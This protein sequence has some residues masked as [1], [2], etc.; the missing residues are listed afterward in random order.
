MNRCNWATKSPA[1]LYYHDTQWGKPVTDSQRLFS[2][3]SLEIFQ[4]GLSWDTVLK[5]KMGLEAVLYHFDYQ[6]LAQCTEKD[7]ESWLHDER[8]IRNKAKLEAVIKNAQ[9]IVNQNLSLTDLVWKPVNYVTIDH[10]LNELETK[11]DY[12]EFVKP[13]VN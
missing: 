7:V 1:Q 10:H 4:A 3:L 5:Y 12:S 2:A 11:L 9:V 6:Q 8:I 13:F